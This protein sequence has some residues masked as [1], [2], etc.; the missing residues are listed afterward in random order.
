[1]GN[2]RWSRYS[3]HYTVSKK[4]CCNASNIPVQLTTIS[5]ESLPN[6]SSQN[7]TPG[8]EANMSTTL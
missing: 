5:N 7:K 3:E 4:Y 6:T 1:M 2:D 8:S